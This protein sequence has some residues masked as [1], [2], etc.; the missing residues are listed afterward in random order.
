MHLFPS[1][2]SPYCLPSISV[3]HSDPFCR[4]DAEPEG[5][6]DQ[7]T[8]STALCGAESSLIHSVLLLAFEG[9]TEPASA[10]YCSAA[11]LPKASMQEA[12]LLV[13][14]GETSKY[15]RHA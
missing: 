2:H 8:F 1:H 9:Y 5:Q 11:I 3:E 4:V 14:E 7:I 10:N 12:E 13:E 6:H 15:T